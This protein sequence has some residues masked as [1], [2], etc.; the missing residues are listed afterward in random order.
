MAFN[1]EKLNK[2][3]IFSYEVSG[4]ESYTNLEYLFKRDGEDSSVTYQIHGVYIGTKSNFDPEVPMVLIENFYVNLPVHQLDEVKQILAD[5]EAIRA[6]NE[7]KAGF[8]IT[9]Y[10]QKRFNRICYKAVW[11]K[12]IEE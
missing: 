8:S 2:K 7:G 6:I 9:T 11:R 10:L 5:P 4:E 3:Q 1:F 12:Y